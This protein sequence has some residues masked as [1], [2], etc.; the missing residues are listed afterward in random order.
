MYTQ[1]AARIFE[2]ENQQMLH[3]AYFILSIH[4]DAEPLCECASTSIRLYTDAL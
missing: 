4:I 1:T 2:M 3:A